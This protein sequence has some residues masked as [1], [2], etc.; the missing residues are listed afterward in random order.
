LTGNRLLFE[1]GLPVA[2]LAGG[3]MQLLVER[4]PADEW[5]LRL[6]LLGR[7][8]AGVRCQRGGGRRPPISRPRHLH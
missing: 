2:M 6:A 4:S 3:A 8:P 1:D 5:E 7:T